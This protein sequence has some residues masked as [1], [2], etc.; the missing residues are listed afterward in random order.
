[1]YPKEAH[2]FSQEAIGQTTSTHQCWPDYGKAL[3]ASSSCILIIWL[4]L[5]KCTEDQHLHCNTMKLQGLRQELFLTRETDE[6]K[7]A[8][9][10]SAWETLSPCRCPG[11]VPIPYTVRTWPVQC[12]SYSHCRKSHQ[13]L[14]QWS[15]SPSLYTARPQLSYR[16]STVH[17]LSHM[18]GFILADLNCNF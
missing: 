9:S 16:K 15:S 18:Q 7:P 5:K 13:W 2:F 4:N 11:C 14:V 8:E 10:P 6:N 3:T 1:M 12:T 17:A